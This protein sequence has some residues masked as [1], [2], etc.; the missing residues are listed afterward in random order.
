MSKA[1]F[2]SIYSSPDPRRYYKTLST[3]DYEIPR[4]S[5]S[6]FGQVAKHLTNGSP[7]QVIDLCCSYAVNSTVM[8]HD[9]TFDEVTSHYL[10]PDI[11][12]LSSAEMAARDREWFGSKRVEQGP[13]VS[14]LDTAQE[15]I[16]YSIDAGLLDSGFAENLESHDP[17]DELTDRLA[18]IDL[19]T[20]SG[21]IGY[22]TEQTF[23]RLLDRADR[24]WIAALC[25]RW[26]DFDP[27]SSAAEKQ[28][29]VSERLDDVTFKQRRF[30]D[31]DEHGHVTSVLESKDIDMAGREAEG[32]HHTDFHLLRPR[33]S[34]DETPLTEIVRPIS[35][36]TT[37]AAAAAAD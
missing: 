36:A 12:A 32:W 29:M 27:I 13:V 25:L 23:T 8:K 15:A 21:G 10:S 16:D 24:P 14:G 30:A 18:D 17:S 35:G 37:T 6:M 19:I 31:D 4:H 5:A 22:I 28:G 2:N 3:L 7:T 20:V 34:V 9:V 33:E 1:D 26:V 11:D